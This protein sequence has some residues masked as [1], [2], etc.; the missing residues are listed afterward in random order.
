MTFLH[1]TNRQQSNRTF[2]N[3]YLIA[4]VCLFLCHLPAWA[5]GPL[6]GLKSEQV[7]RSGT[8]DPLQATR[9]ELTTHWG[10]I[11][12]T[13]TGP[14]AVLD[15]VSA[16]DG[17]TLY[18]GRFRGVLAWEDTAFISAGEDIFYLVLTP[19]GEPIALERLG[20][21]GRDVPMGASATAEGFT[22]EA[23]SASRAGNGRNGLVAI[24]L[25]PWGTPYDE[26]IPE[27]VHPEKPPLESVEDN[28]D[29]GE[30]ED[31]EG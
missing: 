6:V 25:D 5:G 4:M 3:G 30:T 23:Y 13:C 29:E 2:P 31:P 14:A 9:L 17:H 26:V 15:S 27:L 22:I 19:W 20:D 16:G 7:G 8:G 24:H 12:L 21:W 10:T 1:L 18:Y 28:S 11:A